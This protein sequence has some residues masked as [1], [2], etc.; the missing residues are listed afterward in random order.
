[1]FEVHNTRKLQPTFYDVHFAGVVSFQKEN[2]KFPLKKQLVRFLKNV[3]NS[4]TCYIGNPLFPLFG[5]LDKGSPKIPPGF[6]DQKVVSYIY[7]QTNFPTSIPSGLTLKYPNNID[8]LMGRL[9]RTHV[10]SASWETSCSSQSSVVL[11]L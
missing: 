3:P 10:P 6:A 11:K 9:R 5:V 8:P 2:L 7:L 4:R 1:M